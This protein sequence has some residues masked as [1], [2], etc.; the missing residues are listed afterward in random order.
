MWALIDALQFM[1]YIAK[2]MVEFPDII[3]IVLNEFRR[4]TQGEFIYDIEIGR[5][6][7]E[8]IQIDQD[9]TQIGEQKSGLSRFGSDDIL[10]NLG[11]SFLIL[12]FVVILIVIIIAVAIRIGRNHYKSEKCQSRI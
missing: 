4:I 3:V 6:F 2:W 8:F 11:A 7:M 10:A 9:E 1:I 12:L 5:K